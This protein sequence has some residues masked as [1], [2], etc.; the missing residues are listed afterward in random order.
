MA[1]EAS[2]ML[3]KCCVLNCASSPKSAITFVC[4]QNPLHMPEE[5][6]HRCLISFLFVGGTND[7]TQN[8]CL[9]CT[10]LFLCHLTGAL[11]ILSFA[12]FVLPGYLWLAFEYTCFSCLLKENIPSSKLPLDT[13][14][15]PLSS[16]LCT[17]L[18]S[19]Q[20]SCSSSLLHSLPTS[21]QCSS[22]LVGQVAP[23]HRSTFSM[24]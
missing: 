11:G 18:G 12:C 3:G 8:V 13:T 7:T 20:C 23:F 24:F 16:F 2:C 22:Q 21:A 4:I 1:P 17:V 9:S 19:C 6:L 15:P 14:K 5:Y 10:C